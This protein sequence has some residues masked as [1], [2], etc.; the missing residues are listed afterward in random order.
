MAQGSI[1]KGFF[2]YFGLFVLLLVSVFLICLV[3]MMFNP[4]KTVLW[5][6]YF[7]GKQEIGVTHT[8][9]VTEGGATIDIDYSSLKEIEVN[10]EY[11][12]VTVQRNKEYKDDFVVIRNY[13]KGFSGAKKYSPFN[14]KVSLQGTKLVVDIDEPNGFI[15][16]SKD[17]EV[18]INDCT[19]VDKINLNNIALKV[20]AKGSGDIYLGGT[21]NKDEVAVGLRSVDVSTSK[22]TITLGRK[23]NSDS[24]TSAIDANKDEDNYGIRLYTGSGS[25]KAVNTIVHGAK[26]GNGIRQTQQNVSVG[27]RKGRINLGI[28]D[29]GSKTL[30]VKCK[31]GTI[32]VGN[33]YAGAVQVN[34]CVNGNYKFD[35]VS[36]DVTFWGTTDTIISPII[37]IND[38]GG[39][40]R[41][42][43]TGKKDAPVVNIKN[44]QKKVAVTAA[45]G[46]VTVSNAKGEVD[47]NSNASMAVKVAIDKDNSNIINIENEKGSIRLKFLGVVSRSARIVTN[48]SSLNIDFTKDASFAANCYNKD[49][50]NALP[51]SK[52]II[53]LG[54]SKVDYKDYYD[55]KNG[56]ATFTGTTAKGDITINTNSSIN[57]NLVSAA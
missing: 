40:F 8:T 14:Y 52:I 51:I 43:S 29:L 44:A 48:T 31:K 36:C 41:L 17:I 2:F 54:S 33:I 9:P 45:K 28:I 50:S 24:I 56:I 37:R 57:F 19:T 4:G 26:S 13:A 34:D 47:I 21:T 20:N 27:T 10:C 42:L 11:A 6:K 32:A 35:T 49:T 38:L 25:I 53:K 7:S 39:E 23:F 5:M 3:I 30:E 55:E 1:R 18:I 22:G 15:Y 12:K 16:F 46:S